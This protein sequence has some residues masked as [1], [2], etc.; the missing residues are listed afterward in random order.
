MADAEASKK[1]D[2]EDWPLYLLDIFYL[3]MLSVAR[4]VQHI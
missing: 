4:I 3:K 1:Q 2:H